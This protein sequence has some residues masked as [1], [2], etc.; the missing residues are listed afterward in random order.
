MSRRPQAHLLLFIAL[1]SGLAALELPYGVLDSI[2]ELSDL[3]TDFTDLNRV[4][5]SDDLGPTRPIYRLDLDPKYIAYYE[6]DM[7]RNY[8]VLS[9]GRK[10][11]DYRE[12]ESGPDP[13]P[14]NVLIQQA[15]NNGQ[16]C[17]KFYRLSPLGLTVCMNDNGTA[18][19]ASY[20]WT[21]DVAQIEDWRQLNEMVKESLDGFKRLWRERAAQR[22]SKSDWS[23]TDV[24]SKGGERKKTDVDEEALSPGSI[25]KVALG[26]RFK[27]VDVYITNSGNS[28]MRT[29]SRS[30][31]QQKLCQ[32]L[33]DV[34]HPNG[35]TKVNPSAIKETP[36]NISYL[37]LEVHGN[38]AFVG[39]VLQSREIGFVVEIKERKEVIKKHFA[40]DLHSNRT[41]VRRSSGGEGSVS[42][43][44]DFPDY[45]QH[46]CCGYCYSGSGP[47]A[48]AQV[49]GYYDRKAAT[50]NSIFSS[51]IYG[52]S[53]TQA[54]LRLT[55]EVKRF[56]EDIRNRSKTFCEHGRGVTYT[57]N[58]HLIAPWFRSRQGSNSRVA[59]YLE[60]R[61]KRS[62]DGSSVERGGRSWIRSK[63]VEYITSDYPVILSFKTESKVGRAAV[64][65]RYREKSRS[66]RHCTTGWWK[67]CSKWK[68]VYY[69]EFYLHYGWGG[70]NNKW[71]QVSPYGAYV[72]YKLA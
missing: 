17:E 24:V 32:V 51:T 25:V 33:V 60:S 55:D 26:E 40:I 47:V 2:I 67:V 23:S 65:T 52:D 29:S 3:D 20:N 63:A 11:G 12:V 14:T 50:P 44:Y 34:C 70:Y 62:S 68:T 41:R 28:R 1:A 58:M 72:A 61:K 6:I 19:A 53:S 56:V 30:N 18:V 42:A 10:T 13:R 5:V 16:R 64:A 36:N 21:A 57:F 31:W 39:K 15:Q 27:S 71:Q 45:D 37:K 22:R 7:G 8:V 43:E 9:A 35:T 59:S 4:N 48:W 49:F 38:R 69:Y 66:Y 54:P 46:K